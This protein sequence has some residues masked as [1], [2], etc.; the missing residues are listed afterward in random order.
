MKKQLNEVTIKEIAKSLNISVSTVSRA[1]RDT[2]DVSSVTRE[3]VLA[4]VSELNYRPNYSAIGLAQGKTHNIGIVLPIVTNYYFSTVITGIQEIAYSHGYHII[5]YLTND[6][7]KTELE[8]LQRLPWGS[9]DG[10]LAATSLGPEAKDH[11]QKIIN[12]GF[13]VVFFDRSVA[14]IKTS[15]ILQDDFT[16]GYEATKHLIM[17]GYSKIAHL[18]GPPEL[19]ITQKRLKGYKAALVKYHLP[20]ND[21]WIIHSGFSQ[22]WGEKD[23]ERL[24]CGKDKPDAIF[25]INDRKAIGAMVTLKRNNIRIGKEIGVAGFTDDPMAKII[26]PTLTTVAEP[27][28]EVGKISCEMLLK[29]LSKRYFE[30]EDIVLNGQLHIRESTKKEN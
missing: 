14:G 1:L 6:S 30:P 9:F 12:N 26:N 11:Y 13:P 29:H 18:T 8:I 16:G 3:K 25:A 15:Q 4:K 27:A 23:T 7:A 24:L 21:H 19:A 2:F 22:D 20:I 5:L 17:S 10:L 28:F